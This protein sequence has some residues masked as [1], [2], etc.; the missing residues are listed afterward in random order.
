MRIDA[1]DR[2]VD[3]LAQLGAPGSIAIGVDRHLHDL[4]AAGCRGRVERRHQF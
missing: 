3:G 2:R 4:K 1:G